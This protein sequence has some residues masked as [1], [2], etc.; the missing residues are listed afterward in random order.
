MKNLSGNSHTVIFNQLLY[1]EIHF[2][3]FISN[4]GRAQ[5]SKLLKILAISGL[6]FFFFFFAIFFTDVNLIGALRYQGR[7]N[8]FQGGGG[9]GG[10]DC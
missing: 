4:F 9:G 10:A 3:F 6:K 2:F 8:G 7:R 5:P 1:A